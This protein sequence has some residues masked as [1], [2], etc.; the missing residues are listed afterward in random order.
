MESTWMGPPSEV[1]SLDIARAFGQRVAEGPIQEDMRKDSGLGSP[2]EFG[3]FVD[4]STNAA[5][6]NMILWM[7]L[8]GNLPTVQVSRMMD[9]RHR[10]G[11]F[12][13]LPSDSWKRPDAV[14]HTG[15]ARE[16]YEIK[17]LTDPGITAANEKFEKIDKFVS[18][19]GLPYRRGERYMTTGER[20]EKEIK[21]P[22]ALKAL[23][24]NLLSMFKLRNIR[25]FVVWERP[26]PAMI[27][28]FFK[29]KVETDDERTKA[30]GAM[31]SLAMFAL[32]LAIQTEVLGANL[33]KPPIGTTTVE[34]PPELDNFKEAIRASAG[35]MVFD[36]VPGETHFLVIEETGFQR[37]IERQRQLPPLMR[38][39]GPMFNSEEWRRVL[40]EDA[41][42]RAETRDRLILMAGV[43]LLAGVAI[44][45][46]WP[47]IAAGAATATV[48]SGTAAA[49]T[50]VAVG[51]AGVRTGGA[52]VQG[53]LRGAAAN[54]NAVLAAKAASIALISTGYVLGTVKDAAAAETILKSGIMMPKDAAFDPTWL[55]RPNKTFGSGPKEFGATVDVSKFG[56]LRFPANP[57]DPP[58]SP[59]MRM[60]AKVTFS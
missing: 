40:R 56:L 17:P 51:T 11:E 58:P 30:V 38:S 44:Y 43:V 4:T 60:I 14:C 46:C 5:D 52:V 10:R 37:I 53:F 23:L 13:D 57:D 16:Y 39:T 6:D 48:A 19:F 2:G 32:A 54:D 55:L 28:Y 8:R 12:K 3:L 22:S 33:V 27:V 41:I 50:D 59:R 9:Y 31:R 7:G 45:V 1:A 47:V 49:G 29:V 21:I 26:M 42:Q 15:A 35:G 20:R 36:G 18:K 25:I 24:N 34:V